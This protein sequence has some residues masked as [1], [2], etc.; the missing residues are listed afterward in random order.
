MIIYFIINVSI[1]TN[2]C[3]VSGD[4]RLLAG[5]VAKKQ[6]TSSKSANQIPQQQHKKSL[7][8]TQSLVPGMY[9]KQEESLK[10]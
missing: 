9:D 4:P 3:N 8:R 6:L 5:P 2:Y 7:T 1:L 10:D